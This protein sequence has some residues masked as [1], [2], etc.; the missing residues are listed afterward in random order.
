MNARYDRARKAVA[1]SEIETAV[2]F[3]FS[4]LHVSVPEQDARI[5]DLALWKRLKAAS[6]GVRADVAKRL[7]H[8]ERGPSV[9]LRAL[10]C[11]PDPAV[12]L[13]VLRHSSALTENALA[14]IA[15]CKSDAHLEALASRPGL[16]AEVTSILIRRGSRRVIE[17]L[18]RNGTAIF[19]ARC[20]LR[21]KRLGHELITG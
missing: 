12:S 4:N 8:L 2:S 6:P 9:T 14:E 17:T 20:Q 18:A 7:A 13:P 19:S 15:R 10:A 5:F 16:T 11:D 21:L 1:A 3:L